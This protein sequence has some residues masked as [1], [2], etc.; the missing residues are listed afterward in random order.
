LKSPW[1]AGTPKVGVGTPK[2]LVLD[3]SG[4]GTGSGGAGKVKLKPVLLGIVV[5]GSL[6]G[7]TDIP[8]KANGDATGVETVLNPSPEAVNGFVWPTGT[9][10]PKVGVGVE[11]GKRELLVVEVLGTAGV[12]VGKGVLK[13]EVLVDSFLDGSFG[14]EK[15]KP[16]EVFKS[17]EE[18]PNLKTCVLVF[19]WTG[20]ASEKENGDDTEVIEVTAL[21]TPSPCVTVE[22]VPPK[23]G[24]ERSGFELFAAVVAGKS[25]LKVAALELAVETCFS[26]VGREKPNGTAFE[27]CFS[28][29]GREKPNGTA[30]ETGVDSFAEPNMKAGVEVSG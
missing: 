15:P 14:S 16:T 27:T 13:R 29:V 1:A 8:L 17:C 4:V 9:D 5:K 6:F 28:F 2:R 11:V 19:G 3:T 12:V 7:W 21:L 23:I 20:S 22:G 26:F 24:L 25:K 18:E 30:F 10:P